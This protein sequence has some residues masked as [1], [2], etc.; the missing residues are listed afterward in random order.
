[1]IT[2]IRFQKKGYVL[3]YVI[4][5]IVLAT[6][7]AASLYNAAYLSNKLFM[8]VQYGKQAHYIAITGVEYGRYIVKSGHYLPDPTDTSKWPLPLRDTFNTF[9]GSVTISM[10]SDGIIPPTYTINSDGQFFGVHKNIVLTCNETG[11]ILS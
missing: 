6:I 9:G 1:M 10:T 4:L 8:Q 5:T 11:K 2:K 3:V 7:L